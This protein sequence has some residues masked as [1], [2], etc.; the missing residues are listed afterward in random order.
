MRTETNV[1]A[2]PLANP[3]LPIASWLVDLELEHEHGRSR[4]ESTSTDGQDSLK[5]DHSADPSFVSRLNLHSR[6][7]IA[8]AKEKQKQEGLLAQ[9]RPMHILR[10]F[11]FTFRLHAIKDAQETASLNLVSLVFRKM[12]LLPRRLPLYNSAHVKYNM[13]IMLTTVFTLACQYYATQ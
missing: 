8:K 11:S 13:H 9:T 12:S 6:R 10:A 5:A 1:D 2:N 3:F 4:G 7:A